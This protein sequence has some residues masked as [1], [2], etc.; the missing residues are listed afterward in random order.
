MTKACE[1]KLVSETE[2]AVSAINEYYKKQQRGEL[3][4]EQAKKMAA[5]EV[6]ELRYDNG[7]GYFWI[8][9]Y[10]GVNVVLLGRNTE[11]KS[12]INLQDPTG[13]YF[14]KEMLENGKKEGGGFTDLMFAKPN[15]T[16]P[17]PK[18]NYTVTFAPYQ[19]VLGT[20]IWIDEIDKT[21]AEREK[22]L[23][24][25]FRNNLISIISMM[26]ILQILF[27]ILAIYI[28]RNLAEPIQ[29]VTERLEVMSTGDFRIDQKLALMMDK[30]TERGDELG[31]MS[32]AMKN[33]QSKIK[34]LMT[35]ISHAATFVAEASEELTATADQSAGVSTNVSK[36]IG[37]VASSCN[38]Q[39]KNVET[40]DESTQILLKHMQE[41]MEAIKTSSKKIESTNEAAV[42]GR[43]NVENAVTNMQIIHQTVQDI[44]KVIEN[45]G[46]ESQRI[47]KIVDT[48]SA[49][50]EQTNLLALNAAIE[51]ARAGEHGR[52]FAVVS[53]EVRKLAEQSSIAASEISQLITTIQNETTNA[54]AA[55][56]NGVE[57]VN[58]GASSV[59][60]AGESFRH[61]STMVSEVEE[62]SRKMESVVQ[63]LA[64]GTERIT[65]AID[66][67]NE[68][69]RQVADE[70]QS[71]SA[72]TEEETASMN[73][74]ADAS[75]KLASQ[76]QDLQNSITKFK[77]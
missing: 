38:E 47:G 67:I 34:E 27:I 37:K 14:I 62:N 77:I 5:D 73:E 19:W 49:I 56:H 10:D 50:A 58:G 52:G 21:I 76:A 39:L 22:I 54:V 35:H 6:R 68:M 48:I 42:E 65:T 15:E 4:E 55:M 60:D 16:E 33:M 72:A 31:I 3:T 41:F 17:L 40:A 2:T 74:I 29:F 32:R 1:N 26:V 71:V 13:K 11:G 53:D 24:E 61:I 23:K 9:T 66:N 63:E 46:N 43:S 30:F 8:D 36:S 59:N 70:A 28:G 44:S 51:A 69:S 75:R 12:R 45:L 64:K 57:K 7:V 25:Q 20:G 18:R